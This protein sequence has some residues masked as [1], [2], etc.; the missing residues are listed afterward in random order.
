MK[1]QEIKTLDVRPR[2]CTVCGYPTQARLQICS[3]ACLSKHRRG[4]K[5]IRG[6]AA[7]EEDG[8]QPEGGF[9]IINLAES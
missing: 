5:L 3:V 4:R 9:Q 7:D 2:C 6:N 1:N 8:S